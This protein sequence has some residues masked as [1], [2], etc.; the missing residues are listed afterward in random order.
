M[1]TSLREAG[2]LGVSL[3]MK[4]RGNC[5][6]S[7]ISGMRRNYLTAHSRYGGDS[8]KISIGHFIAAAGSLSPF[9][10]SAAGLLGNPEQ[11]FPS[12]S[13]PLVPADPVQPLSLC[14]AHNQAAWHVGLEKNKYF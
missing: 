7:S 1:Q 11:T 10:R 6:I 3:E 2:C 9:S 5:K 4:I 8:S 13:H 14:H 12:Q